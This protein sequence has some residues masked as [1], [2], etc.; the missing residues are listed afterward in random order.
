MGMGRNV[1]GEVKKELR[2]EVKG[3]RCERGGQS[4][5]MMG[6]VRGKPLMTKPHQ[7]LT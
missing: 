1:M 3:G 5:G 7:N 6:H 4:K 2:G